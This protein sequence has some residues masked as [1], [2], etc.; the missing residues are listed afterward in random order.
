LDEFD[1]EVIN[2][3]RK[4]LCE[5]DKENFLTRFDDEFGDEREEN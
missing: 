5:E 4:I 2:V 1:D 3:K